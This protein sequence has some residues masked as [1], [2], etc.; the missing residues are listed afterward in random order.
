MNASKYLLKLFKKINGIKID[1]LFSK[2]MIKTIYDDD[3]YEI[4]DK[5]IMIDYDKYYY[6]GMVNKMTKEAEG[7]GRAIN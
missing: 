3:K 2:S 1:D 5:K 7:F 6:H 4:I